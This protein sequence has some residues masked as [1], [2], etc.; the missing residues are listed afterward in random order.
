MTDRENEEPKQ[1]ESTTLDEDDERVIAQQNTGGEN[2]AGGGEWPDPDTPPR[3]PAPGTA[4]PT[5]ETPDR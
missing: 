3:G 2:M 5:K 4:G 1:V